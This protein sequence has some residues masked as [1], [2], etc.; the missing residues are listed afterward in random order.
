MR[1]LLG[2]YPKV[3]VYGLTCVE[4]FILVKTAK[5]IDNNLDYIIHNSLDRIA[6]KTGYVVVIN[7]LYDKAVKR[8]ESK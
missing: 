8:K 1:N 2:N 4:C 7:G 5:I 6:K 3:K